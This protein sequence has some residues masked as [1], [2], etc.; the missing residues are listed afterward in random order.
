MALP[1]AC[2]RLRIPAARDPG[3]ARVA[4]SHPRSRRGSSALAPGRCTRC[5]E[6][7]SPAVIARAVPPQPSNAPYAPAS[8]QWIADLLQHGLL[9]RSFVPPKQ[10]R[11]L[12][13]LTRT[14][15]TL[16]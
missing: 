12:R 6:A 5:R 7:L 13:D 15:A 10:I 11:E 2:A 14:R 8:L 3:G 4:E 9:R 16:T 1:V